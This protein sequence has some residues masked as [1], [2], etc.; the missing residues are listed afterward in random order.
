MTILKELSDVEYILSNLSNTDAKPSLEEAFKLLDYNLNTLG[1]AADRLRKKTVG[2]VVTFVIDTTI[3]NTNI[4]VA[5]CKFCAF[6]REKG[7]KDAYVLSKEEILKKIQYAVNLGATQILI[8]GGLNPDLSIEYYEDIIKAVKNKFPEVRRHFFSAPEIYFI[9]KT[10]NNSIEE[11]LKRLYDAGLQSIPGGGAELLDDEIRK[12]IS[13]NKISWEKW[14]DVMV[15]AHNIGIKTTATMVYGFG[16]SKRSWIKHIMRI[17]EIQE[18][19]HGFTAFIPWSYQPEH[20][21]LHKKE[22]CYEAGGVDYLEIIALS[23]ILLNGLINNIQCSWLTEGAKL[24]QVA[25]FYGANDFSGTIIEENVVK[26]AGVDSVGMPPDEIVRLIKETGRYAA[27]R[28]TL[29]K[30]IKLY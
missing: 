11:T 18:K 28:D 12:K 17:R 16:E 13:P 30:I 10:S 3:N 14:R 19:T 23:R 2:D 29:Y 4:C 5:R 20:T 1:M 7:S 15:T 25:L 27:Q 8:Q 21:E 26:A 6:Y 22:R 24:G 9:A